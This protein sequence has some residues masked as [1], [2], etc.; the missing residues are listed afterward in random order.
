[1]TPR[2]NDDGLWHSEDYDD[3]PRS[4]GNF[5]LDVQQQ[6]AAAAAAAKQ[7]NDFELDMEI[8]R[9][10]MRENRETLRKLADG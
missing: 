8:A 3:E 1:M 7:Q 4:H 10:F 6:E 9:K 2:K 5:G